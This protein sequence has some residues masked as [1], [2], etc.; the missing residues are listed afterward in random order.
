M[1]LKKYKR[2]SLL[3]KIEAESAPKKEPKPA[4][5]VKVEK[6]RGKKK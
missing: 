2:A 1:S 5:R 4:K 3:D 6:V